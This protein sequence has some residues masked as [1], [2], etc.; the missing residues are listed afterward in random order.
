MNVKRN[1]MLFFLFIALHMLKCKKKKIQ[2]TEEHKSNSIKPHNL[3]IDGCTKS[4]NT[5]K[6]VYNIRSAHRPQALPIKLA[7][8]S[9]DNE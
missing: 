3:N 2:N 8:T 7:F 6:I 1:V 4:S 9:L 5:T